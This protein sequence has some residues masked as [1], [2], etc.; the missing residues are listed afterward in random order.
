[1]RTGGID[2]PKFFIKIFLLRNNTVPAT[3]LISDWQD[4]IRSLTSF[5][6]KGRAM[7]VKQS[8]IVL[9]G[10]VAAALLFASA[11]FANA[12]PNAPCPKGD[13]PAP[14][15]WMQ[16]KLGLTDEQAAQLQQLRTSQQEKMKAAREATMEKRKA[17]NEA[18]QSGADEQA[19][20]AAAAEL[21]TA[22]GDA[23]VLR[24]ANLAEVKKILTPDQY[25]KWQQLK[26][27]RMERPHKMARHRAWGW[28][29][30]LEA[31]V[32]DSN[33]CPMK[34]EPPRGHWGPQGRMGPPDP[35]K[36]FEM[37]DT[38][39]DGKL[40]L[41]EF[42][43]DGRGTAEHFEKADTNG[44]GLVTLEEFTESIKQFMGP[45]HDTQ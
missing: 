10:V 2:L 31:A 8:R 13:R 16:K 35:E 42:T 39:G 19:I 29:E 33:E 26:Q 43:A 37:K 11:A 40:T 12:D 45:R 25:A 41:E 9:F 4:K 14:G 23:A 32:K 3:V 1:L 7:S 22:L 36:I 5:F 44:D 21:G 38:N 20:R 17:L 15:A 30:G 28:G 24:A 6:M 27:E 18:V 34:A